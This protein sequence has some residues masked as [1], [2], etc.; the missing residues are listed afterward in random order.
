MDNVDHKEI[1]ASRHLN[2]D[3][4]AHSRAIYCK[5]ASPVDIPRGDIFPRPGEPLIDESPDRCSSVR[6]PFLLDS[7]GKPSQNRPEFF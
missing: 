2:L 6:V 5:T 1:A 7:Q 3:T 4:D